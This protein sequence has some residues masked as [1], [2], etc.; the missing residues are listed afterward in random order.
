MGK[1]INN[2]FDTE[3]QPEFEKLLDKLVTNSIYIILILGIPAIVNSVIEFIYSDIVPLFF[4]FAPAF[5]CL[6][7][8]EVWKKKITLSTRI[9]IF[10]SFI[11]I[12][13]II[14]LLVFRLNG[15]GV[16]IL[17]AYTIMATLFGGKLRGYY[18]FTISLASI[19]IIAA[20]SSFHWLLQ[21]ETTQLASSTRWIMAI[22]V[23]SITG[24][25]IVTTIGTI[26]EYLMNS[27][28]AV[29]EKNQKIN[30]TN[31]VL[32]QQ[33]W[34][35]KQQERIIKQNKEE[36]V[37]VLK[38]LHHRVK[39]NLQFIQS[40]LA[41]QSKQVKDPQT[42]SMF[43]ESC[44]RIRSM[45]M[46]HEE[47]Y[48]TNNFAQ[49]DL[50]QYMNRMIYHLKH[51]YLPNSIPIQVNVNIQ[52]VT[53]GIDKAI[54]CGL[55]VNEL[56]TN[57]MQHAF[58]QEH[59]TQPSIDIMLYETEE[60]IVLSVSDNGIGLPVETDVKNTTSLGLQ[61]VRVLSVDQLDGS[62]TISRTGGTQFTI[63]FQTA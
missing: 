28:A 32:I 58:K 16:V 8:I 5:I 18:Y 14:S 1:T 12:T 25:C 10:L 53:M 62:L 43:S 45:A 35:R 38:E 59:H 26:Q 46:V 44:N 55:I 13:G 61:L 19:V 2:W 51:Q 49:V 4:Y 24:L 56:V 54:P 48:H 57:A 23:F 36:K 29:N 52:Q 63:K 40:L 17:T 47:L 39:N 37:F 31:K 60:H 34:E 41:L 27:I 15:M 33:L 21:S 30:E 50:T 9:H 20:M 7:A 11:Y 6:L 22:I 42:L 3:Y